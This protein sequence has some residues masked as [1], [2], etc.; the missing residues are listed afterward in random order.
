MILDGTGLI[1]ILRSYY[2]ESR[3]ASPE[4]G[5]QLAQPPPAQPEFRLTSRRLT[6]DKRSSAPICDMKFW[7]I[8]HAESEANLQRI[9][10]NGDSPF[11]LTAR[12]LEHAKAVAGRFSSL[13]IRAVYTS[14]IL[15]A[16]QTAH[17]ICKMSKIEMQI[18][19]ELSEYSM[20]IYEGTSTLPGTLGAIADAES[21][22]R[23]F[24]LNDFDARTPGGESL[25][26]MRRRFLPFIKKEIA[27]HDGT[28]GIVLMITH[29]GI[30]SA[31]LPFVFKNLDFN[32]VQARSIEH[33][34][35]IKGELKNG[36]PVCVEYDG[37]AVP[38]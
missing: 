36:Q 31:M 13:D 11:A 33:L 3:F 34:S 7:F 32:F 30:L 29:G 6:Q 15:R 1:S 35:I 23:W 16:K 17:E 5:R 37:I 2:S 21:K 24:K 10:A 28:P 14:P 12:G 19:P 8:R 25:N 26:D 4:R 9:Y 18:A 38:S 22:S 20:G 27:N